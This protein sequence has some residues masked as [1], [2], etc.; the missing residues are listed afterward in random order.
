[1]LSVW[2]L[3][4]HWTSLTNILK[5]CNHNKAFFKYKLV[6]AQTFGYSQG[7]FVCLYY[8]FRDR[9]NMHPV[10][11]L[12]EITTSQPPVRN[13]SVTCPSYCVKC[14]MASWNVTRSFKFINSPLVVWSGHPPV[15]LGADHGCLLTE[16]ARIW[17][18]S[19]WNPPPH[20]LGLTSPDGIEDV[21][22]CLR[23]RTC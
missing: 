6:H 14:Q 17:R 3:Q 16:S 10:F 20:L 23:E 8:T 22:S 5:Y 13:N 15:C 21:V 2:A 11:L 7:S 12:L 19:Q 4:C 18:V 9:A 1:M